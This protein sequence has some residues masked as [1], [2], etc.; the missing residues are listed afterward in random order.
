MTIQHAMSHKCN[1]IK[2]AL[3]P[4]NVQELRSFLGLQNY[5]RKFLPNIA[6]IFK[7]L[8]GLLRADQPWDWT[9]DRAQTFQEAKNL[10]TTS[11]VLVHYNPNLPIKM[12]ADASSELSPLTYS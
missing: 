5:N 10:L 3:T 4:K 6:F 9:S 8:N 12:A 2:N 1:A 11:T 7:P